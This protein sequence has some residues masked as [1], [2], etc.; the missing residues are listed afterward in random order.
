MQN[1]YI[2]TH[3]KAEGSFEV[4]YDFD[5]VICYFSSAMTLTKESAD[6]MVRKLPTL[7][8]DIKAFAKRSDFTADKIK[9]DMSFE[10]WWDIWCE[11]KIDRA[12]AL[13]VWDRM[14]LPQK[15]RAFKVMPAYK[16]WC[17]R[18]P[19]KNSKSPAAWLSERKYENDYDKLR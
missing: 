19:Y 13:K 11:G 4:G 1:K 5:G 8:S 10:A 9:A 18:N 12:R 15:V 17:A 14:T 6:W 7:E 3:P 2:L 16:R